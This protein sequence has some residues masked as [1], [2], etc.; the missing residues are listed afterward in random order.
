MR[1]TFVCLQVKKGKVD[2][3]IFDGSTI[4]TPSMLCVE[5]YIDALQWTDTVGG[6]N[7]LIKRS[8][9]TTMRGRPLPFFLLS[10]VSF[11]SIQ[12]V[13]LRGSRAGC[14]LS[15]LTLIGSVRM[16]KLLSRDLVDL[17]S[18]LITTR[19]HLSDVVKMELG[20]GVVRKGCGGA[21][22]YPAPAP[23][24]V[25]PPALDCTEPGQRKSHRQ[26]LRGAG[27]D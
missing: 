4:N 1:P 24:H 7:G 23:T 25:A 27:L 12:P 9:V 11:T 16:E 26:V 10:R 17:Y 20:E 5:D 2:R 14:R 21:N 13:F 3:S 8:E 15:M 6:L 19:N 22:K 18:E